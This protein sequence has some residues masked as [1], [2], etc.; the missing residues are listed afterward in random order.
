MSSIGDKTIEQFGEQWVNYNNI[1]GYFGSIELFQDF[2]VPF[3][4]SKLKDKVVADI[5]AGTGRFTKSILQSGASHVFA[6]EPSQAVKVVEQ[7]L[8][9]EEKNRT[10]ILNIPGGEL[11]LN[12]S[13]DFALSIGVMHHI[14]EVDDVVKAVYDSLKKDGQ[15]IIWL[16]GKEGNRLYLMIFEPIRFITMKMPLF[17]NHWISFLLNIF[18]TLYILII[19]MTPFIPW[20][21][22]SYVINVISKSNWDKRLVVIFDQLNPSYAKYYTKKEAYDLLAKNHFKTEVFARHG[23]SWVVIGT[24]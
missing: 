14:P 3:D 6:V 10:T 9:E 19:K 20:P 11:K 21:M 1:D 4:T 13:L 5:G 18:L 7:V 16:Y 24:K 2:V 8:T 22:K 12:E 23:Y 15:F 17:L